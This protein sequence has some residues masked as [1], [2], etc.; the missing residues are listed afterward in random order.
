MSVEAVQVNLSDKQ[1]KNL[2]AYRIVQLKH[3]ELDGDDILVLDSLQA[4]KVRDAHRNGRGCRIQLSPEL[5]E[6]TV[7]SG[8]GF[9]HLLKKAKRVVQKIAKNPVVKQLGKQILAQAKGQAMDYLT[10]SAHFQEDGDNSMLG[11]VKNTAK[12]EFKSRAIQKLN[13]HIP[14]GIVDGGSMKYMGRKIARNARRVGKRVAKDPAFKAVANQV[15]AQAKTQ[16]LD[17]LHNSEHLKEDADNSIAGMIK[18]TAKRELKSRA[19]EQLNQHIPDSVVQGEGLPRFINKKVDR[20]IVKGLKKTVKPLKMIAQSAIPVVAS[21]LGGIAG[22]PVGGIVGNI[23]GDMASKQLSGMGVKS[24]K[25]IGNHVVLKG[26]AL[27]VA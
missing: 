16:A 14:D 10:G 21:A 7:V 4:K 25:L 20:Q 27:Y 22:G 19:I 6:H 24:H 5:V 26:G 18:N 13:E 12:R 8:Q 3:S 17:M 2:L 1:K 11:L 15:L 9:G 23:A